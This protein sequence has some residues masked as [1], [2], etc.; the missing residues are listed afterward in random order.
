M[1]RM[2]LS[3]PVSL[4]RPKPSSTLGSVSD[5]V[6]E[7]DRRLVARS[8][9]ITPGGL[10]GAMRTVARSADHSV[11]W[12][13]VAG[14][15]GAVGGRSR[16][17]AVRGLLAVAGA[18]VTANAVAKPLFPRGRPPAEAVPFVRR[19]SAPPI[20]SSF[21]SGHAASAAAFATGVALESPVAGAVV[22]PIAAAV[23]YSRVHT[24]VHWP[25]DIAA[26]ALL[27]SGLALA[28]RRW[29]AVRSEEPANLGPAEQAPAL[30]RGAG[31]LIAMNPSSGSEDDQS[32][33]QLQPLL[34]DATVLVLRA[35]ADFRIQIDEQVRAG[36]YRAL[37]VCGGDGTVQTV[38]EA[39]VRRGLPLAV[40]PGGTLNHFARDT[41]VTDAESTAAAIEL[42][43]SVLVDVAQVEIDGAHAAPFL[44]TASLGGYPDSVRLRGKW[45]PRYGKWPAAAAAMVRVLANAQPLVATIDGEP[46]SVWMLFVG[47]GRYSPADRI[48][49]SRPDLHR[50]TLDVRYLRA[51]IPLSRTRLVS[52]ALTGTLAGSAS[53]VA[54]STPELT[55]EVQ[56][57]PVALATDGEAERTGQLFRFASRPRALVM[58]RGD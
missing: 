11:L 42:G 41:G 16:R 27:G 49:M 39:A 46:T 28:T 25:S 44:N 38:A 18:S 26:G 3:K 29:W 8:A 37:G 52:A 2:S 9:A 14:V 33:A 32:K 6:G 47:N 12:L 30:P 22:A 36:D 4:L 20:S 17:G 35:D 1:S 55:I 13:G 51:D 31:L 45:E 56:G 40:F 43:R 19:L 54:R 7:L 23:A 57:R 34:P 21:P 58:Y 50:G 24:G 48:P 15:L 5:S 53:Y 10:D